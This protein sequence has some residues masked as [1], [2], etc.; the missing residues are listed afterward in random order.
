LQRMEAEN[1]IAAVFP[2][3]LACLEN[4]AGDREIPDHP[5]VQQTIEDCLTEAMDIAGL[6]ALLERMESGS[7]ACLARDL[8]EPSPLAHEI[9]NAKPY[10]FLDNAPLEERRTQ[11]VYTRRA[12]DPSSDAALGILDAGAIERVC[13]EAWPR[14]AN[15]DELHESL[16]LAGVMTEQEAQRCVA[17]ETGESEKAGGTRFTFFESLAA[18]RRAGRFI[19]RVDAARRPASTADSSTNPPESESRGQTGRAFRAVQN[20]RTFLF[21]AERLTMLDAIYSDLEVEPPLA[22]PESDAGR[23]WQRADAVR[24]LIR[25][26][27]EIVGP[28]TVSAL[29]DFFQLPEGEIHAALLALEGEGFAL[30]GRFHPGA[31]E[32]E[33]CDRRLLARIHRLTINRLRAEIQPV[34]IEEFQRFLLAWQRADPQRRAEGP[35]GVEAVLKMLDGYESPATAWEPEVLALRVKDYT[36]EWLDRLCFTGRIGWG[37][38]TPP[39]P[40]QR[41]RAFTP[42]RSSPVSLFMRENLLHWLELSAANIHAVLSPDTGLV[43]TTLAEAGALF[44]SEI[45]RDTGLLPSRVEQALGELAAQGWVTADSFEGLRALLIPSEKRAPFADVERKRRHKTVTSIEFAGRWS[46]LRSKPGPAPG[47]QLVGGA[48][49][50][51]GSPSTGGS[52][53]LSNGPAREEAVEN[54][55][56]VLLRRYGVVFRRLLDKEASRVSWYELGRVYRR[57]EARG[58]IRGGHFVGGVSGEQFALSEAIGLLRSLRKTKPLGEMLAISAADPLNLAGILT[59]GRRVPAIATNRVLLRDGLPIAALEAGQIIRMESGTDED[60]RVIESALRIGKLPAALRLYY[61]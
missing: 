59:P 8:P 29:G 9:L 19:I 5:L 13:E 54:Y 57:Q 27:M 30:R 48:P 16:L 14:A 12:G 31:K 38:L 44:F 37:R 32:L 11:A 25:G 43:L 56:Q 39:A 22:A 3:Q 17:P 6:I 35:E 50:K 23:R 47:P 60:D 55:A 15:A 1:L 51:S 42:L 36:P 18:E 34:T 28:T 10:A 46:L 41:A 52:P 26:R 45:V 40:S 24:E 2:D 53:A 33:W 61:A 4:I 20:A 21:A 49:E 7:V 58:E